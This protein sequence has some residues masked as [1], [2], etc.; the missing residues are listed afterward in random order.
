MSLQER[1]D[2]LKAKHQNL[3]QALEEENHRPHPDDIQ[4]ATLKKQKLAIKDE[5]A[6][7]EAQA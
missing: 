4:I 3:E 5:I 7:L 6:S 1:I 2:E